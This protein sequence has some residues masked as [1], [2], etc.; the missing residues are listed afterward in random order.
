MWTGK[1]I[2][3]VFQELKQ[4]CVIYEREEK[5]GGKI[6]QKKLNIF[7][8]GNHRCRLGGPFWVSLSQRGAI[9]VEHSNWE[10]GEDNDFYF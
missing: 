6:G 8:R 3:G 9:N 7:M 4:P 2:W 1:H 10:R 5:E